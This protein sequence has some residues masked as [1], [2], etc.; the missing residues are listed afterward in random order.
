MMIEGKNLVQAAVK[1]L[2]RSYSEMDCQAFPERAL[3]DCGMDINLAGSN[4]WIRE[5][6]KNGA[7]MT[8]EECVWQLGKVPPG[9]F[10]FIVEDDGKE[11]EKYRG[12]GIGNAS[13]MGICTDE[14]ADE[15]MAYCLARI[16]SAAER[17]KFIEKVS[18]G[19]GAIHSSSSR[20]C[21]CTSKFAGKTIPN[22]GWNRVG[23]WNKIAY[24]YTGGGGTDP[25]P[26]PEPAPKPEPQQKM[27][28]V[29]NVPAGN[30]QDVNLRTKASTLSKPIDRVPCGAQVVLLELGDKWSK[31]KWKGYTGWMMTKYLLLDGEEDERWTVIIPD[32]T[33]EEKEALLAVYPQA[34]AEK[35]RG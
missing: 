19:N 12:D 24:D 18:H 14:T 8:P 7:V 13:H 9:A 30:R 35:G 27:A 20:G 34:T 22:G 26:E 16:G 23:L 15:M 6:M 17:K 29:G 11:P 31:V 21:V 33:T 28:T 4:T 32:V 10:L 5:V 25:A 2:G 3:S 1:Y